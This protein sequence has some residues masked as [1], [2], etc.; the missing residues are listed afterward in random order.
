MTANPP[1]LGGWARADG[2]LGVVARVD[3]DQVTLFDPGQRQQHTAPLARLEHVPA[4]AVRITVT[5]DLPLPHGLAEPSLRRWVAMLTDPVLRERAAAALADAGLDS[6]IAEPD[7][8]L[9]AT[10]HSD[11]AARCLC[12]AT[13]PG[14]PTGPAAG[15]GS[16]PPCDVCGRQTAPPVAPADV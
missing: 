1:L 4:A 14:A 3:G 6:G 5:V 7:A 11:G 16:A 8:T 12:G 15:S 10:A 9:S 13:Q 2:F